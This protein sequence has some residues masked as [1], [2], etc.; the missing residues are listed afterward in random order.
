MKIKNNT[1]CPRTDCIGILL[2][3]EKKNWECSECGLSIKNA[4]DF[5]EQARSLFYNKLYG[6]TK[7]S[8]IGCHT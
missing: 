7:K 6:I 4:K 8:K 3:K 2:Q 5:Q 1:L